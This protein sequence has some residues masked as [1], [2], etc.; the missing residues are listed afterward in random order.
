MPLLQMNYRAEWKP[1]GTWVSVPQALTIDNVQEASIDPNGYAGQADAQASMT[2]TWIN[3]GT[4]WALTPLRIFM[5][6]GVDGNTPVEIP[7]FTGVI[8]QHSGVDTDNTLS[9]SAVSTLEYL[10][11]AK[12]RTRLRYRPFVA[13]A[14]SPFSVEDPTNPAYQAGLMNEAFWR[15]GGRP[16]EQ[17]A[18]YP[19]ALFYYACD[20]TGRTVEY[21]WFDS[22]ELLSELVSLARYAGGWLYAGPDGVIR[23]AEPLQ[24]AEP[25][26]GSPYVF[27]Q[28]I[29]QS[30][31]FDQSVGDTVSEI[32]CRYVRRIVQGRQQIANDR[33]A[34]AINNGQTLS[35]TIAMQWP[36]WSYDSITVVATDYEGNAR[37]LSVTTTESWAQTLILSITNSTGIDCIIDSIKI[38]GQPLSIDS[39]GEFRYT[40]GTSGLNAGSVRDLEESI[41]TQ[42][43]ADAKR[44][45][46]QAAQFLNAPRPLWELTTNVFDPDRYLGEYVLLAD[47]DY[48]MTSYPCRIIT[49]RYD[50]AGDGVTY[51]LLPTVGLPRYTDYYIIGEIYSAGMTRKV[52]P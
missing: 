23:Y 1:A 19:D 5:S 38:E 41:Y 14:T 52:A 9:Y 15:A 36:V 25:P 3:A 45:V 18:T 44:R 33:T 50:D 40:V 4:A 13:T 43:E 39:E 6:R 27:N 49:I 47:S 7:I 51:T 31:N 2:T 11:R 26:V 46:M 32:T 10:R 42:S 20:G 17:E 48:G 21:G 22:E 24:I 12:V 34:R 28:S 16:Y 29:I 35:V 30:L 37:T 8:T